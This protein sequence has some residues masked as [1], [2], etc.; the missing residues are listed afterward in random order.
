MLSSVGYD[1]K[2]MPLGKLSQTNIDKAYTVLKEIS[3]E[4]AKG[5]LANYDTLTSLSNKFF[6]SIPHDVG[7]KNM[8]LLRINDNATV[9]AK[10]ELLDALSNMKITK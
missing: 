7:F 2:K 6:S 8:R 4:L 3:A 10:L 1:A 9:D 5:H